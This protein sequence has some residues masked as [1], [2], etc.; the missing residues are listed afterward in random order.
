MN[1][2]LNKL[3]LLGIDGATWKILAPLISAGRLPNFR[4]LIADG[5]SRILQS[6]VP[7][8]SP[9]AWTSM[10]TGVNPG[11]H[12]IVDFQLKQN[13]KFVPCLSRYRMTPSIWR[14]I[15]DCGRKC[16]II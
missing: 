15:S 14:I 16:I 7:A 2:E 10:F 9:P 8:E 13:G 12:G 6:T 11:K 5:S 4:R 1:P 3:I